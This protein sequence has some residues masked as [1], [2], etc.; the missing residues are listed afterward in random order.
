V[1]SI[2]LADDPL[3]YGE[4]I[5]WTHSEVG[6][7]DPERFV[8]PALIE[9]PSFD[10]RRIPAFVYRPAGAGPH[11]VVISIHG[12]PEGQ[13]RP[14][15]SSVFQSWV[16]ELG[17]AVVDPNVRGSSGY[18]RR[19]SASTTACAARTRSATSARCSTGSPRSRT[20]T[21]TA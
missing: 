4:L 1:Y 6:G 16:N 14:G 21:R 20:S 10:D 17:I 2:E 12:G 3:G 19:T 18:G 13:S 7:L 11:P 5:R 8:T 9:Y 15:F